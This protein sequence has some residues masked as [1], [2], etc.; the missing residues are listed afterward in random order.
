MIEHVDMLGRLLHPGDHV[1]YPTKWGASARMCVAEI[2]RFTDN[3]EKE[4]WSVRLQP[5]KWT[6][7]RMSQIRNVVVDIEN[8][9]VR[10]HDS[11]RPASEVTVHRVENLVKVDLNGR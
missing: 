3:E 4:T 5:I 2:V 8:A 6:N 7:F 11:P 9:R 1:A 10:E